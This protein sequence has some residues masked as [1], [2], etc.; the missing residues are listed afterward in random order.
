MS[1][2]PRREQRHHWQTPYFTPRGWLA[3]AALFATCFAGGVA[4]AQWA[5][6]AL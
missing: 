1:I 2:E 3:L 6:S 4:L 5:W